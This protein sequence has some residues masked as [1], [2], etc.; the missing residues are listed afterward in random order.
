MT[1][2]KKVPPELATRFLAALPAQANV[3]R[4]QMFGC[5]CAFV[6]GNMFAGLHEDRLIVRLPD[7]AV[8]R[9]CVIMGR[10]MKQYALFA[11]ALTLPPKDMA[12]WVQRG[13]A[14][15]Q[16][17]PAKVKR[18]PKVAAPAKAAKPSRLVKSMKAQSPKVAPKVAAS[19]TANVTA[20]VTAKVT[21]KAPAKLKAP[22][23]KSAAKR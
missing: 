21:V 4:R 9:P 2:W 20:K 8:Q 5:P 23:K 18:A 13:Y 19:V 10:T 12:Q 14:F 16:A 17:L 3:E 15:T 11:D 7:E 22:A 1:D 6:N